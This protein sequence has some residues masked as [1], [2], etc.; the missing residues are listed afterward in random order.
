[1][2]KPTIQIRAAEIPRMAIEAER[3]LAA[4]GRQIYQR[5]A[6]LVRPVTEE[7]D[8]ADGR[9]THIAQL[10]R[11]TPDRLE[12][13]LAEAVDLVKWNERSRKW[14]PADVPPKVARAVLARF[15]D[16]ELPKVSGI[17]TCPTL[18]ADGELLQTTGY[19]YG[20]R[21]LLVGL[22]TL[23]PMPA[24]P[25]RG[26]ALA[27]LE[28]LL[29]LLA[30]FPFADAESRSVG[31]SALLTPVCRGAYP[32]APLHGAS[33]PEAGSGKSYL[34]DTASSIVSGRPCPVIAPGEN[35]AELEK[36]LGALLLAG[37]PLI[38]VDNVNGLLGG[39]FLC[40]AVERQVIQVR[41]LGKSE[42][43]TIEPRSTTILAT[44]NNLTVTGDLTRRCVLA[45]LDA[46]QEHPEDRTF[47]NNPVARVLADR[48]KYIAACLSICRA[49]VLAGRPGCLDPLPSFEGWSNL[50]RSAL[51]WLD[52]SDPLET[53]HRARQDDPA[54]A[55][56]D[57]LLLAWAENIGTGS[58]TMRSSAQIITLAHEDSAV[59]GLRFP[60]LHQALHQ[61]VGGPGGIT[62]RR[63]GVW[64]RKHKDQITNGVRLTNSTFKGV[65]HWWLAPV[66][67]GMG[68]DRAVVSETK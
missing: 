44:G 41:L 63:L 5:G 2:T 23:P 57:A 27:A 18:R 22:P 37:Q 11:L 59:G 56:R 29:D 50:V 39:D 1:M 19:D 6:D 47:R 58:G 25:S 36:R 9:R 7:V 43:V 26:D 55:E 21:L 32:T 4:C 13:E 16:W 42:A 62:S 65:A 53:L 30:E 38:S 45:R 66:E 60:E 28:L 34:M 8:A 46:E 17:I 14:K 52:Q 67:G 35:E 40:Q 48:G 24:Q 12:L 31:L 64:L 61:A 10:V 15:G 20:T 3:A 33:S 54:K 49:Y 51:V 68:G